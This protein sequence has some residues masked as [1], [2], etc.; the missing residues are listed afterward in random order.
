M[1]K[2]AILDFFDARPG[3]AVAGP[4][5][6]LA[7]IGSFVS[8]VGAAESAPSP[9]GLPMI[10]LVIDDMGNLR[11]EGL[12][13]LELP[14][15]VTYAFLPHTPHGAALAR[16]AHLLDK[17]VMVHL[18]MESRSGLRL[19]PGGLTA[20]MS[21][22]ELRATVQA[23]VEAIPHAL[24][25]SNHMGSLLT[26]RRA[27]M[28]WLMRWLREQGGLYFIDSRTVA[29][30]VAL[31]AAHDSGLSATERDV[32]LDHVRS[33][34]SI[35]K[36]FD[37]LIAVALARGSAVGIGHPYPE[38]LEVLRSRLQYLGVDRVRLVKMSELLENNRGE[39]TMQSQLSN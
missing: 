12:R 29:G 8:E 16:L 6:T 37:R 32:F 22:P 27:P 1:L 10:A 35:E 7:L 24:G 39:S 18:P 11:A 21:Q 2:N 15:S 23:S 33:R 14:G 30:S 25:V 36:Q 34:D 38:T 19:G 4:A 26:T 3:L 20:S 17:E 13:A 5:L 9:D 28:I 31:E